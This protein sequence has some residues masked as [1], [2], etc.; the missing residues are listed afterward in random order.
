MAGYPDL[1]RA[2]RLGYGPF[3][4]M[5]HGAGQSYHGDRRSAGN[6][7][8][9]G[10]KDH[11]DVVLFIVPGPD[12][13]RWWAARYPDARVCIAGNV[14][15]LPARE[16]GRSR[17]VAV[18]FHWPCALIPEVGSAWREF[19]DATAA[20]AERWTV[21]GHWHP[22]W[23]S[24]L[25]AWYAGHGIEPVADL[26]DVARRSDVLI[27]DN[28]SALYEYA[29]TDRPVI[30]LNS[31]RYRRDVHHGLRFWDASF[32]GLQVDDPAR[33]AEAVTTAYMDPPG[34]AADRRAAVGLVYAPGDAGVAA[35]AIAA[36]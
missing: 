21:L 36:M 17:V 31:R 30:V 8:Y 26:A 5:Q 15:P 32:V 16:G 12:P 33:L 22:R 6:Q 34:L 25:R 1:F 14:K 28:T 24:I 35:A 3:V 11:D 13:A 2:R 7:S 23:G 9:A 29:A 18:T 19:R 27:A 10:A 4:L 20:L